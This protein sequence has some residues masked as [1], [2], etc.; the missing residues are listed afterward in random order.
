MI[1]PF[2]PIFGS[3][4]QQRANEAIRCY[5]AHA[6]LACCVMC[7]ASAESILLNLA[8]AKDGDEQRVLNKYRAANGR[9]TLENLVIG[10]QRRNK[11]GL[12]GLFQ[13]LEV[14]EGRSSPR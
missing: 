13:P 2:G 5:G 6:Y 4:F 1:A 8:I 12:R 11:T 10:Q 9:R 7:G 14:L 3:G